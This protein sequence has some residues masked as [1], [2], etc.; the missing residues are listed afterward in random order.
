M[1]NAVDEEDSEIG[2]SE[3]EELNEYK[4]NGRPYLVTSGMEDGIFTMSPVMA[5]IASEADVIQCDI[6]YD[7][8]KGYPY[9]SNAVA[10]LL[11]KYLW[12]GWL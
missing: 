5:K 4:H 2:R 12:S 1:S 11:T 8:C 6:T 3:T 9:I 7:D 10:L